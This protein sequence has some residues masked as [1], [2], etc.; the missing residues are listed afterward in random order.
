MPMARHFDHE[1]AIEAA[2][3]QVAEEGPA[4]LPDAFPSLF[5]PR[6]GSRRGHPPHEVRGAGGE[7]LQS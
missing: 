4:S 6:P 2:P 5:L 1:K 3:K 7:K